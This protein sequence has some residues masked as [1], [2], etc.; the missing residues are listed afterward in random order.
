MHF[1]AR[2]QIPHW[3]SKLT[4]E[5]YQ[6]VAIG[7]G[8]CGRHSAVKQSSSSERWSAARGGMSAQ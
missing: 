8:V 3:N 1:S 5:N 2:L 4:V 6:N 7:Y